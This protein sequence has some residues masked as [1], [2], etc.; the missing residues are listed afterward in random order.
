LLL[1]FLFYLF[2][3]TNLKIKSP[4]MKKVLLSLILLFTFNACTPVSDGGSSTTDSTVV[5]STVV[6]TTIVTPVDTT[7]VDT[8][9]TDSVL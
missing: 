5:D 7:A 3:Q 1:G 9:S 2:V 6:D 8:L 4:T